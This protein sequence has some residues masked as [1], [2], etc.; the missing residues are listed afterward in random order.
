M[1]MVR[2]LVR[3][4]SSLVFLLFQALKNLKKSE[5]LIRLIDQNLNFQVFR[6]FPS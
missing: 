6:V 5:T 1:T 3:L 2:K 4:C